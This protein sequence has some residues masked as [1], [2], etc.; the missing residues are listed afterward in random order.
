[1]TTASPMEGSEQLREKEEDG[2]PGAPR[3]TKAV[4]MKSGCQLKTLELPWL[5][6]RRKPA[7]LSPPTLREQLVRRFG[8]D[9]G[10]GGGEGGEGARYRQG[11]RR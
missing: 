6:S 10:E 11:G 7:R 1:M 3:R 8:G 9:G 2:V 5:K 4:V